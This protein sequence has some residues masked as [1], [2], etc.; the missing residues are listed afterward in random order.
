VGLPRQERHLKY[1]W[2]GLRVVRFFDY[3]IEIWVDL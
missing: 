3:R 1:H 2:D